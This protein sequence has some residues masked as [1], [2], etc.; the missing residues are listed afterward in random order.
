MRAQRKR[1]LWDLPRS[2]GKKNRREE[3][4]INTQLFAYGK[5]F[6]RSKSYCSQIFDND[7]SYALETITHPKFELR[8]NYLKSFDEKIVGPGLTV[9]E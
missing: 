9:M 5:A 2:G 3:I 6:A 8:E 7:T 4:Q 1:S